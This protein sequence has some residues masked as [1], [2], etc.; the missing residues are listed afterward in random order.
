MQCRRADVKITFGAAAV[1]DPEGEDIGQQSGDGDNHHGFSRHRLRMVKTLYRFPE[2]EN[3]ND[4]QGD[5]VDEG[6]ESS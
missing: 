1:Q 2:D 3:G 5:G 6:G 4:H